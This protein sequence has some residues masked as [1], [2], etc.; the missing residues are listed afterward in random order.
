MRGTPP[1][2]FTI[3][4][5][6]Y[7]AFSR[8]CSANLLTPQFHACQTIEG[9]FN[10]NI[11]IPPAPLLIAIVAM[12]SNGSRPLA[13]DVQMHCNGRS[14]FPFSMC[15]LVPGSVRRAYFCELAPTTDK[16]TVGRRFYYHRP[17][18]CRIR[19]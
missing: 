19:D 15:L 8:T 11:S 3:D 2:L 17:V 4:P 5:M 16:L 6:T 14:P 1:V 13:G 12:L 10:F 9:T 18:A 7:T